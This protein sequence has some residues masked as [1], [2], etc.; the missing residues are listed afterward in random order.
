MMTP[1]EKKSDETPGPD[2]EGAEPSERPRKTASRRGPHQPQPYP[3]LV[4]DTLDDSFPASD[5]PPWWG[6]G[7]GKSRDAG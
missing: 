5:P 1:R 6:R 7:A 4:D 2:D 3:D